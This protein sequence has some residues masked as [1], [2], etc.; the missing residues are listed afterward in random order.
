MNVR[1]CN[2]RMALF[3]YH[4]HNLTPAIPISFSS[5]SKH[6]KIP[7]QFIHSSHIHVQHLQT[8]RVAEWR[9]Y[10]TAP[11]HHLLKAS[12]YCICFLVIEWLWRLSPALHSWVCYIFA[13]PSSSSWGFTAPLKVSLFHLLP[14]CLKA[15]ETSQVKGIDGPRSAVI[16]HVAALNTEFRLKL[17]PIKSQWAAV[18]LLQTLDLTA[19]K[20]IY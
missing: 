16:F 20:I 10:W 1:N 9:V 8:K 12:I 5:S 14:P 19:H 13:L 7:P 4:P 11:C 2:V 18:T 6:K 17:H 3:L 15:K